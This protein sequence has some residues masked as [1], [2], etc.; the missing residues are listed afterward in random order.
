MKPAQF[1]TF[2]RLV[3]L[4]VFMAGA[5]PAQA[6]STCQS[7][8]FNGYEE[9]VSAAYIAYY[10]RPADTGGLAYW[11]GQLAT[12]G[13][14]LGAIID[15]FGNSA[16][17]RQ[18]F[19]SLS[20]RELIRN[21]YQQLY[22]RDPDLAGWAFYEMWLDTGVQSL[23]S[24]AI[25]IMDGTEGSDVATL[26][27][28]K[29]V[30][31]HFIS[32]MEALGAAAPA[33]TDGS[34]LAD[35][36]AATD[37]SAASRENACAQVN[38]LIEAQAAT[39]TVLPM[40][41]HEVGASGSIHNLSGVVGSE[42]YFKLTVPA[43][44]TDLVIRTSRT[45]GGMGD[46]DLHVSRSVR[47]TPGN[48]DCSSA[49]WFSSDEQCSF[50]VPVAGEYF[51]LLR[52]SII[53]YSGVT[54]SASWRGSGSVVVQPQFVDGIIFTNN[55]PS[56][57]DFSIKDTQTNLGQLIFGAGSQLPDGW[58]ENAII[59]IEPSADFPQGQF[60]KIKKIEFSS[61]G[62]RVDVETPALDEIFS[63]LNI[64]F[65]RL[66]GADYNVHVFSNPQMTTSPM[67]RMRT[68]DGT[69]KE[70][71]PQLN[72]AGEWFPE[73]G[74][75]KIDITGKPGKNLD[76][77]KF[78][79]DGLMF[80]QNKD[81]SGSV[82]E[83]VEYSG[84][85]EIKDLDIK[86][87]LLITKTNAKT[88]LSIKYTKTISD[89]LNL[90][91]TSGAS[92]ADEIRPE[93][94][95]FACGGKRK[96]LG[97][98]ISGANWTGDVCLGGFRLSPT[99]PSVAVIVGN[100]SIPVPLSVDFFFFMGTELEI[101]AQANLKTIEESVV[102]YQLAINT[103]AL[104]S[105]VL[106]INSQT[107]DEFHFRNSG[108]KIAPKPRVTVSGKVEGS[109]QTRAGMAV[110]IQAGGI[111]PVVA[112]AYGYSKF[113][114]EGTA[115]IFPGFGGIDG[116]ECY[117]A[118]IKV[119]PGFTASVGLSAKYNF[120]LPLWGKRSTGT[121]FLYNFKNEIEIFKDQYG[122]CVPLGWIL[123]FSTK[124]D[125]N[126]ILVDA[127][128]VKYKDTIEVPTRVEY[129]LRKLNGL[130]Y[131]FYSTIT[132]DDASPINFLDLSPGEYVI[133]IT[134]TT[135]G[136]QTVGYKSINISPF[137]TILD[138]RATPGDGYVDLIWNTIPGATEYLLYMG[139]SGVMTSD[140]LPYIATTTA[141]SYRANSLNNGTTYRFSTKAVKDASVIS[142]SGLVS[143][144]PVGSSHDVLIAGRYLPIENGSIVR[145]IETGLE[146]QRCSVGQTWDLYAQNCGTKSPTHFSWQK[147]M[148]IIGQDGFRVPTK[149]EMKTLVY[150][151]SGIPAYYGPLADFTGQN[152]TSEM[153]GGNYIKPVFNQIAFKDNKVIGFD[154][155]TST[156]SSISGAWAINNSS[157]IAA[158]NAK[159]LAHLVRLV[160][161]AQSYA[162]LASRKERSNAITDN[163]ITPWLP[164]LMGIDGTSPNAALHGM[165]QDTSGR[166]FYFLSRATNLLPGTYG[167]VQ[168]L[169]GF[170][171][172]SRT[173]WRLS[174]TPS[175]EPANGDITAFSLAAEAD[176]LVFR[177]HAT[178]LEGGP[179]LYLIDL[180]T[181]ARQP[182]LTALQ[183]GGRDPGADNPALG[184]TGLGLVFDAPDAHGGIQ[185]FTAGLDGSGLYDLRQE[186]PING[187]STEA[188]CAA[189]SAD[190]RYMAWQEIGHDDRM[191]AR[192]LNLATDATAT[193]DWPQGDAAAQGL[194][195]ALSAD[196]AQLRWLAM[197][198]SAQDA[199]P[200]YVVDNPL[201]VA[202]GPLH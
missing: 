52:G 18:R 112:R 76:G 3:C 80:W 40:A 54:L 95:Q 138:L 143:S 125:G 137:T 152:L 31:R 10:G 2:L 150:C 59:Y 114:A 20:N 49:A 12:Q 32:R 8:V 88:D 28:R 199:A 181:G 201:F 177:T 97:L 1:F 56:L 160:R 68:A 55:L 63:D 48:A 69:I 100:K 29:T 192:V 91:V 82:K 16:E 7:R 34:L 124:A 187:Q 77:V 145:D 70:I 85:Y 65:N 44:V 75:F 39:V 47:P 42:R 155:W 170:D 5:L 15:A 154:Y 122:N 200:L 161:P 108:E 164:H 121:S 61:N 98:E 79:L 72:S 146:W 21:L 101:K 191:L 27:N 103:M 109:A 158:T 116:G 46:V 53:D 167:G 159:T 185:V 117:K 127:L 128:Q 87:N 149:N 62:N 189:L 33:I 22:G 50:A 156:E 144:T 165:R 166:G 13:G 104:P 197:P 35:L 38:T 6:Q 83:K 184:T 106:R 14:N 115:E 183:H 74:D 99:P 179:G 57:V 58:N 148:E 9:R 66:D 139:K 190:G 134:A 171:P 132:R 71:Q 4:A 90:Q 107:Y 151:S 194:R 133:K 11:A 93:F 163:A 86:Y 136:T 17:Y 37:G 92:S 51:I 196:G 110:G 78:A 175:G 130:Q 142:E 113:Y 176:K 180:K 131:D 119:G 129:E 73:L 157:G 94:G 96:A 178:N 67:L 102:E 120:D 140:V 19:G 202:A 84:L 174:E 60:F 111:Y 126:K 147:A 81:T 173:L 169:Y 195:L 135:L 172:N 41:A 153:C 141:T 23:A 198:D 43:G 36:M 193:L 45:A 123:E 162:T 89:E 105:D 118:G 188:C 25:S 182:L 26:D 64:S 186:T 24:I 168:H 30:A